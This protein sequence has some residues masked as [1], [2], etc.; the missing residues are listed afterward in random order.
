MRT[1]VVVAAALAVLGCSDDVT[2]P[3]TS[4][5]A[6]LTG[7]KERPDPVSTT[8]S[9]SATCMLEASDHIS[10]VITY[11]NLSGAP[12]AAHI[13]LGNASATGGVVVHLCGGGGAGPAPAC[14]VTASGTITSGA[15]PVEAAS[16]YSAVVAAMRTY[17]AYV[18]VHTAANPGGE[19][20]SQLFGVY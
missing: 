5:T 16:T 12:T 3:A 4:F 18:N 2:N 15:Q 1:I 11:S 9:G 6:E 10:C 7:A 17:G 8:G 14:P 13:H 20:R 19:I